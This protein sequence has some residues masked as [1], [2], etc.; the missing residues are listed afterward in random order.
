MY[1][2][3][4]YYFFKVFPSISMNFKQFSIDIFVIISTRFYR[5]VRYISKIQVLIYLC[6]LIFLSL[7]TTNQVKAL[8]FEGA[9]DFQTKLDRRYEIG[10]KDL[11][12]TVK[13]DFTENK[14]KGEHV[15]A[16]E[17]AVERDKCAVESENM[18]LLRSTISK[19]IRLC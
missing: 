9:F 18:S 17:F 15:Q 3:L 13:K 19:S 11:D 7:C 8:T 2:C 5:Y 12:N 14:P 4:F 16:L 1:F 10:F 6:L